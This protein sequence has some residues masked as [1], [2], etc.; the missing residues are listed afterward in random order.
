MFA[1]H[2]F[3]L[4]SEHSKLPVQGP[5][6]AIIVLQIE[7]Y[8]FDLN[9]NSQSSEHSATLLPAIDDSPSDYGLTIWDYSDY[10]LVSLE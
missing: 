7:H 2:E 10:S 1:Q 4:I 3:I 8:C 9:L 6:P 5:A